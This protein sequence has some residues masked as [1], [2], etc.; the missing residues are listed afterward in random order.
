MSESHKE[1]NK[2]VSNSICKI[3]VKFKRIQHILS[4]NTVIFQIPMTLAPFPISHSQ[5]LGKERL[6]RKYL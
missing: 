3:I 5:L 4:Q 6:S 1:I 2:N